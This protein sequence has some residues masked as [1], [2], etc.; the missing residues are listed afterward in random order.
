MNLNKYFFISFLFMLSGVTCFMGFILC[1]VLHKN[2]MLE[3]N[4][5]N[6]NSIEFK[7]IMYVD[8]ISMIFSSVVLF[9]SSLVLIY[10]KIYM[11]CECNRF[12]WL[13]FFFVMFMLI[14]ILSPSILGVV[15]GWD[16]LGLI[17]YCL[18][19]YYQ[20][21]GS[22]NSGFITAASNR[23]GD[24]LLIL[25]IVFYSVEG[26]YLFWESYIDGFINFF[27]AC[28]TKSAQFPF[29]AWLPLAM[30]APTPISS[31]VHSSTLVTAGVYMLIR[32]NNYLHLSGASIYLFIISFF[33]ITIAAFSSFFEFDLKRIIAFSTLGQLG[34]MMMLLSLGESY[35]SFFHLLVHALFKALLF[36][37][38]GCYIFSGNSI[39]DLRK[40]GSVNLNSLMKFSVFI[41]SFSLMGV[42]FSSGFYSKDL[43]LELIYMNW[44]GTGL[45]L[46]MLVAAFLTIAYS[47]R[48]IKFMNMNNSWILWSEPNKELIIPILIMS[49]MNSVFGSV[50][51][52]I[53][54]DSYF[55]CVNIEFKMMIVTILLI[56]LVWQ[57]DLLIDNVVMFMIYNLLYTMSISKILG[58]AGY[59]FYM[60]YCYLDQGWLEYFMNILKSG[61]KNFS[62]WVVN[63]MFS[64]HM[65]LYSIWLIMF[66]ILIV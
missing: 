28:L 18:V 23:L 3:F 36:M 32:F 27:L 38:A 53:L 44:G 33:T 19:I 17:S 29:S 45:G 46:M 59:L 41:S 43:L 2:I 63:T 58:K 60:V 57:G 61:I 30:A 24:S 8:W 4:L 62:F 51:N 26:N 7:F 37:C 10:S 25:S 56:S 16:G 48:V 65:Y 9:I 42:P 55:I 64:H 39:Q 11:S 21:K 31:L 66:M 13:T 40:M 15:L 14:M 50:M 54:I 52:W 34:F 47:V 5:M 12:L 49:V 35:I 1:M 22:F 20:S 6:L